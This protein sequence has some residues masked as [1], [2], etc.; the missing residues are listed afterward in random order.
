MK[1]RQRQQ[2]HIVGALRHRR[3]PGFD[4]Q[5]GGDVGAVR[6]DHPFRGPGRAAAHQ[7][8]RGIRRRERGGPRDV[9]AVHQQQVREVVIAGLQPDAIAVT[10]LAQQRE[11]HAQQ[12]RE[13]LLDVGRDHAPQAGAGLDGL[14]A[15]VEARER[16]DRLDGVI[17][18]RTFKLVLRVDRVERRDDRAELPRPE[19]RDEELGAVRQ[20]Q[21]DAVAAPDAERRERRGAGVAQTR[22]PAV[23]HRRAFEQQRRLV[24]LAARRVREVID[25][26]ASGVRRER[27]G[28]VG[29]VVSE[30]GRRR[31]HQAARLY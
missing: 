21:A 29:I 31:G 4:L 2:R 27:R 13:I 23:C 8:D 7:E 24:G 3:V 5:A 25:Q 16:D 1:E 28:D 11:Q 19:F 15:R 9:P 17:A 26:R 14:H 18:Q 22:E 6:A 10:R 12:R 20:E 30:P